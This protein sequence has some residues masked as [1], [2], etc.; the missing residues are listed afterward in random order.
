MGPASN[1]KF[2]M[3]LRPMLM[4]QS[5]NQSIN[6]L[7]NQ[8]VYQSVNQLVSQPINQSVNQL[9]DSV[10]CTRVNS[11]SYSLKSLTAESSFRNFRLTDFGRPNPCQLVSMSC[12]WNVYEY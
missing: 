2:L 6:R 12:V 8:A 11:V 1:T 7:I 4:L 10:C 9:L 5:A 3:S